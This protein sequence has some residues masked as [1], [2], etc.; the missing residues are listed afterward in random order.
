MILNSSTYL[1]FPL[2]VITKTVGLNGRNQGLR[3][4]FSNQSP[5]TDI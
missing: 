2:N 4:I 3:S 1:R 5:A